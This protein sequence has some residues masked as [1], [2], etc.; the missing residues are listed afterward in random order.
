MSNYNEVEQKKF[1]PCCGRRNLQNRKEEDLKNVSCSEGN[2]E[3]Y[4]SHS[5]HNFCPDCGKKL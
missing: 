5:G 2:H 4:K 3:T 1:C